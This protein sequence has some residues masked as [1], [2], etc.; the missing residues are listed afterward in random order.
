MTRTPRELIEIYW[1]RIYNEGEVEFV[2]EV[3]ADPII[4]HDPGF[5]TP[6]SHDEQI[7][8]IHRS[9]AMKPL[10]THRVLHADDTFVTSVWNMVSRDGRDIKLCGIEVFEAKEGRFT[11]CWNSDYGK[12]FWGEDGDLFD[13]AALAPPPLIEAPAGITA[14]WLQRAFAAGGS[15]AQEHLQHHHCMTAVRAH[16]GRR[17]RGGRLVDRLLGRR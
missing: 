12:G 4:R 6:L 5:V 3:C 7:V 13:P 14:D 8:R 9:L 16:E 15:V 2:R 17:R 10:F 1:E 11:R